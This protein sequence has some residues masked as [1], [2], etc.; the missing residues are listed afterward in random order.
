MLIWT[1]VGLLLCSEAS[2][3]AS[4]Q[5][6]VTLAWN[7]VANPM[8]AG[9]VLYYGNASRNYTVTN[10]A[11]TNTTIS[12][13]NLQFGTNYYFAVA[14]Y[15]ADG[16]QSPLSAEVEV[17]TPPIVFF[18]GQELTSGNEEWLQFPDGNPFGYYTF[19]GSGWIDHADMG[20][21]YYIDA[22]D[23]ADGV[24]FFDFSSGGF[25]YT[26]PALFPYLFDFSLN[27]WLYYYADPN[28]PGHYTSNP[29]TF[30]NYATA[31]VITK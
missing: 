23:A 2:A 19:A 20:Y 8:V 28:N 14:S 13:G 15:T 21:E 6:S 31:Q 9:Y 29:R 24:Y 30:Y 26:T 7:G 25:W 5:G 4:A 12:I 17:S 18:T 11:G 27:S 16:V 10:N 3:H 1:I 22:Q